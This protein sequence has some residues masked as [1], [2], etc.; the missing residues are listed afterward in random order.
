M[1]SFPGSRSPNAAEPAGT[2]RFGTR[3]S[4]LALAQTD[5]VI[6]LL[7]A[8]EP[9]LHLERVVIRTE[10]DADKVTP[11][12]V[13]GGR[14]VFTTALEEALR[15]RTIEV[16]VHS[17]KDL[18][19]ESALGL[20]LIAFPERDDPRDVLVSR[21][22]CALHDLPP[23]PTIGTSSRR[24][25]AQVKFARPDSRV[26]E[27]RGNVDT[28]LRKAVE[29]ELDGILLAAAGVRRM[30]WQDR[31]TETLSLECFVPA[32]GQGALAVEARAD[33]RATAALFAPLDDPAVSRAVR[34]ERAFLHAIG[35][36]C[37][38]PVGAHVAE[39]GGRLRLLAMLASEDG[40]RVDW[41]DEW[42]DPGAAAA[43]AV[44]TARAMLARV[45]VPVGAI[46]VPAQPLNE[47]SAPI[48]IAATDRPP[49][50]GMSVLVTRARAQAATLSA[51]LRAAGAEPVEW[52]TIRFDGPID[53][54]PLDVALGRLVRGGYDWVVFSSA[55][56]VE[57]VLARLDEVGLDRMALGRARVAALGSATSAALSGAG[58]RVDLV[59]PQ[60]VAEA[61]VAALAERGVAGRRVLYP[62]ADLAGDALPSGLRAL[63]A[64][65]DA[66]QAYRTV[67][68]TEVAP[69]VRTRVLR[70]EV[71]V[72]TFASASSVRNLAA[73]L[74]D[75]FGQLAAR[76]VCVG[77][78]TATAARELGLRVDVVAEDATTDGLV[79][80]LVRHA[81][82]GGEE[83][84]SGGEER[85]PVGAGGPT[86]GRDSA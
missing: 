31:V 1:A 83:V 2:I 8:R 74:G 6:R 18:P 85:E 41:I 38:T 49:L 61:V 43:H 16:A 33:D 22:R 63:G 12:T 86:L 79:A 57:R 51:A 44:D 68:V 59:P 3:G 9:G 76:I 50:A 32:P 47:M 28:R 78:V 67:P 25:A 75:A 26:V 56:S 54:A 15:R 42:L 77:P 13:I 71:D 17:A 69:A 82:G 7:A 14:G 36:G 52:P 39:V 66:V 11:L 40:E 30:G 84:P 73:S 55:N 4:A 62:H 81:V 72:I 45:R 80:A 29:T 70:G 19:S 46:S 34:I 21:H 10:G 64:V 48:G 53:P 27:L 60:F 37:T 65:V 35:G 24:R 58:V 23:R 5:R 20:D